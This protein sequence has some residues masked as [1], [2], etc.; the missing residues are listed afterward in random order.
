[1]EDLEIRLLIDE[2]ISAA[3]GHTFVEV[4]YC[5]YKRTEAGTGS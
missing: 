5:P 3:L 1:M 2:Q 4:I